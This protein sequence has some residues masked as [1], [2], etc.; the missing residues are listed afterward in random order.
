MTRIQKVKKKHVFKIV[1]VQENE[2]DE[3]EG[4]NEL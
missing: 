2:Y 3:G 1:H 4:K